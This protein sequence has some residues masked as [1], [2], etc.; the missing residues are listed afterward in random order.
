MYHIDILFMIIK[1]KS[2]GHKLNKELCD[3]LERLK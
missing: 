1:T 3:D 2:L